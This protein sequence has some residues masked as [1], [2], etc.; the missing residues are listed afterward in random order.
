MLGN[1]T[2]FVYKVLNNSFYIT[3]IKITSNQ[4]KKVDMRN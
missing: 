1:L 4:N 3:F 2:I